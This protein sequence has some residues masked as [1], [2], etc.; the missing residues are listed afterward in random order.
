MT[1]YIIEDFND[2]YYS[3]YN[4]IARCNIIFNAIKVSDNCVA[5]LNNQ[6]LSGCVHGEDELVQS[7]VDVAGEGVI[8]E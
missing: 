6:Q 2:G 5:M 1:N 3:Y 4:H 8:V 7:I